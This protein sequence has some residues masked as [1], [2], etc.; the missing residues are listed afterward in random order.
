MENQLVSSGE[1][2]KSPLVTALCWLIWDKGLL[3][4]YRTLHDMTGS[5]KF[6]RRKPWGTGFNLVTRILA[7]NTTPPL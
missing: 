4:I 2:T 6:H 1:N 7:G 3:A 5:N